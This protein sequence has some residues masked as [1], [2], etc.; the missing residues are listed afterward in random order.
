M[1]GDG[2]GEQMRLDGRVRGVKFPAM[3]RQGATEL[4]PTGRRIED[5]RPNGSHSTAE[6]YDALLDCLPTLFNAPVRFRLA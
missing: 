6:G 4:Y 1:Q 5:E 3:S 2:E